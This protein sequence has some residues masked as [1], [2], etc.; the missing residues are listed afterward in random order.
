MRNCKTCNTNKSFDEFRDRKANKNYKC[1]QCERDYQKARYWESPDKYRAKALLLQKKQRND[2]AT[3]EDVL[4][5]Q[6]DHYQKK[7]KH[8]EKQY[9][10]DMKKNNPME[11]RARNLRRNITKD[12][13]K[14]W[15]VNKYSQQNCQ[16]ALTGRPLTIMGFHVDHIIPKSI[17]G[18]HELTNLRLVCEAANLAKSGMT[19]SDL[20]KLCSEILDYKYQN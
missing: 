5:K 15:L 16:C 4:K 12:I 1:K 8:T 10:D 9:Y 14:D 13:T 17:G 3:R 7:G 6:R 11:W 18:S 19:D 20:F 2:S